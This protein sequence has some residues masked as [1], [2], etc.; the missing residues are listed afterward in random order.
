MQTP[1]DATSKSIGKQVLVALKSSERTYRG[2]LIAID[3]HLNVV[4]EN[5][6]EMINGEVK[7]QLGKCIIRGDNVMFVSL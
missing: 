2:K 6:E 4:L 3:M 5:T 7:R 1:L